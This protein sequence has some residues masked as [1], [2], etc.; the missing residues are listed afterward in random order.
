MKKA[1][2]FVIPPDGKVPPGET[3]DI[4][5]TVSEN[6]LGDPVRIPVTI[7]NGKNPGPCAFLSAASHGDELNGIEIIR[8]RK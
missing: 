1:K 3:M 6:Y 5:Y 2:P 4:R 7:I 8:Q